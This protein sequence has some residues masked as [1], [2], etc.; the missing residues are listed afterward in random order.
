MKT[1]I[2]IMIGLLAFMSCQSSKKGASDTANI[3][4]SVKNQEVA[5]LKS[6]AIKA[7]DAFFKEYSEKGIKKY[8]KEDYIQH[9]PHVPSGRATVINFL[10]VL[11]KARTTSQTHRL[12]QDGN[13]VIFHNSYNNAEAFGAK[14]VVTFDIWRMENGKVAEHWDCITPKVI[15]TASGRTQTGGPTNIDDLDK[16][17]ENKNLVKNFVNDILIGGKNDKITQYI[18]TEKYDQ[19]N[20]LVKDGLSG[21]NEAIKYLVSQNDMFKYHKVHRILGEGNFVLAQSEGEWHGKPHAFY[22]LFRVAKGKIVEH[23]DVIQEI[24]QK[25]AHNNGMF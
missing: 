17:A 21:L 19:H 24:P 4:T 10:P 16:T 14:E 11:K 1:N 3:T 5:D 7:Q 13:F 23:W 20:P 15:K 25:M 2:C 18:S 22:D 6:I 12:L 8:F 9:N